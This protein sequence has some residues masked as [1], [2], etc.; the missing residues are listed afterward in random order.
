MLKLM[1]QERFN[2]LWDTVSTPACKDGL[3]LA[4]RFLDLCGDGIDERH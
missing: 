1:P 3:K 4:H 2:R